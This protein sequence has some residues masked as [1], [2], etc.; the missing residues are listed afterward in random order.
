MK[1]KGN[2][3]AGNGLAE[4]SIKEEMDE[5]RDVSI[6]INLRTLEWTSTKPMNSASLRSSLTMFVEVLLF[7]DMMNTVDANYMKKLGLGKKK[8]LI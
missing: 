8:G 3:K 5:Q 2:D 7:N 4:K 1:D 6:T